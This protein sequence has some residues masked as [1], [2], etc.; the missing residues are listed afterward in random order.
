[1]SNSNTFKGNIIFSYASQIYIILVSILILPFY[2]KELGAEAFGLV[3]FFAMLQALFSLLDVGLTPVISRETSRYRA[4][5]IE[6]IEFRQ[7]FRSLNIIFISIACI[8]GIIFLSISDVIVVKWLTIKSLKI[9]DVVL[10]V[11]VMSFAVILKWMSGFYRGVIAGFEEIVWI[12]YLNIL[13]TS[14]RYL[15]VFPVMWYFDSTIVVFFVFQFLVFLLEFFIIFLKTRALLP[16]LQKNEQENLKWSLKPLKPIIGFA[17]SIAFTSFIWIIVTQ[18]DK[19]IVS[20]MVPLDIYGYFSLAVTIGGGILMISQPISISITPRMTV[21]YAQSKF[22]DMINIYRK[23]TQFVVI[24]TG[25]VTIMLVAFASPI[26]YIWTGD[27]TI[28]ANVAP[29]MKLYV[30]GYALLVISAF[31][32]YLQYAIG[33]MKLHVIGNI[34]YILILLPTLYYSIKEFGII[35]AGYTWLLVNLLFAFIWTYIVHRKY[36]KGIHFQW[37]YKDILSLYIL[38][39]VFV[40]FYGKLHFDSNKIYMLI[41]L[42]LIGFIVLSMMVLSSPHTRTILFKKFRKGIN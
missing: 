22:N 10:A 24:I 3:G 41:E 15:V 2:I 32:F 4:N 26:L 37:I 1:V 23:S 36:A 42:I 17:L 14:L 9:D 21:L 39:I 12:S 11:Q 25:S 6:S 8:L 29:I 18:I 35:G 28:V 19:F 5:S 40:F 16:S 20:G 7:I 13:I 27:I 31:P 33:N 34:F 38:P 30:I